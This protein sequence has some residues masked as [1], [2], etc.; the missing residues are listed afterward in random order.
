M[1]DE[2]D[3]KTYKRQNVRELDAI[4][5]ANGWVSAG[6][7]AATTD[8]YDRGYV[9]AFEWCS[10]DPAKARPDLVQLVKDLMENVIDPLPFDEAFDHAM[11]LDRNLP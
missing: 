9:Y 2:D 1:S 6:G 11:K 7:V 8:A 4:F 5:H 3:L 10:D